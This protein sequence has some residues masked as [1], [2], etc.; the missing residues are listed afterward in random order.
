MK[1]LNFG[2][3]IRIAKFAVVVF[4]MAG[5]VLASDP[6][7]TSD[8]K[9]NRGAD[10]QQVLT[11]LENYIKTQ[12][13][14][15]GTALTPGMSCSVVQNGQTI[16][17]K[18]FGVKKLGTQDLVDSNTVFQIGSASKG[19]TVA[20]L[21]MLIDEG[22]VGWTDK[23]VTKM[24]KFAM[25]DKWVTKN[26]IVEDLVS[27]RSGM[28]GYS[29]DTM[30][31]LGYPLDDI[32]K[33]FRYVDQASPFRTQFAYQNGL[34]I[35]TGRMI[36]ELSGSTWEENLQ[37][38]IFTPLGMSDSRPHMAGYDVSANMAFGH[39]NISKTRPG[40]LTPLERDWPFYSVVETAGPAG[41]ICSTAVDMAKWAQLML[42]NGSIGETTLIKSETMERIFTPKMKI[43]P[44]FMSFFQPLFYASCWF[45]SP[46]WPSP[47]I[48]H[49][50]DTDSMHANIAFIPK[51][52]LAIIVLTNSEPNMV[53]EMVI[54]KFYN[55]Y[56]GS[57]VS[58]PSSSC[59]VG[60]LPGGRQLAAIEPVLP[61]KAVEPSLPLSSYTRKYSNKVYKKA[62]VSE[63]NGSLFMTMGPKN[64]EFELIFYKDDLFLAF[65]PQYGIYGTVMFNIEN[66]K[67]KSLSFSG[68]T[69]VSNGIF[70]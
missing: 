20:L 48:C 28:P 69:E 70:K 34:V 40:E 36:Y 43:P 57:D 2:F 63:R 56:F 49:G 38:R 61:R 37:S 29:L 62:V 45:Y 46:L 33:S 1:S 8:A 50:G 13:M 4:M 58:M 17:A 12:I 25:S 55:L 68:A 54:A 3:K 16:Y 39:R 6:Q 27:H 24:P 30:L 21:G 67:V 19:F 7:N 15:D 23:V 53:P 41:S 51:E 26:F 60:F 66:G 44:T 64:Y 14:P 59:G 5:T 22:K 65:L 42:G 52:G 32:F 35:Y 9:Q 18:G 31:Y 10:I 47:M 11:D